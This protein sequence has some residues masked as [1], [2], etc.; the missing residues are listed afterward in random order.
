MVTNDMPTFIDLLKNNES[1]LQA[2]SDYNIQYEDERF[3]FLLTELMKHIPKSKK[4]ALWKDIM[5]MISQ[6]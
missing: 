2:L 3:C 1:I 6:E 4:L 5:T